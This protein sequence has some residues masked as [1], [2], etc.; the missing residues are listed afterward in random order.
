MKIRTLTADALLAALSMCVY[1][2]ESAVPPLVAVPGVKLGLANAVTLTAIYIVG[3][4][5]AMCVLA[6][7]LLLTALIFGNMMSFVFSACAG[8][9]CYTVMVLCTRFIDENDM[10]ATSIFG[11][12]AHNGVQVAIAAL[13]VGTSS[14]MYYFFVLLLS[15]VICGLFTGIC[16]KYS[17]KLFYRSGFGK[18]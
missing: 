7:R 15:A 4:K 9:A 10:W 8:I 14:L 1:A 18:I 3:K 2:I 11:A 5:N 16:A 6:V 12:I 13:T 17:V